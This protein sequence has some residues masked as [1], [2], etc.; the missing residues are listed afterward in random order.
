MSFWDDKQAVHRLH[1]EAFAPRPGLL[2][3]LD[4]ATGL[5]RI[6]KSQEEFLTWWSQYRQKGFH[7]DDMLE[8]LHHEGTHFLQILNCGYL[9]FLASRL[10]E[11]VLRSSQ[12]MIQTGA[13]EPVLSPILAPDLRFLLEH[14]DAPGPAR[15]TPRAIVE[16]ATFHTQKRYWRQDLDAASYAALLDRDCPGEDYRDAY[17]VAVEIIGESAYNSFQFISYR[18]LCSRDPAKSF[19]AICE[20]VAARR[21]RLDGYDRVSASCPDDIMP[22][23]AAAD[24]AVG[25]DHI[26]GPH[27]VMSGMQGKFVPHRVYIDAIADYYEEQSKDLTLDSY[28]IAPHLTSN[29]ILLM[30]R[31]PLLFNQTD[32]TSRAWNIGFLDRTGRRRSDADYKGF[33]AT[34]A[35]ATRLIGHVFAVAYEPPAH[36]VLPPADIATAVGWN[37]V[38]M[39]SID[40]DYDLQDRLARLHYCILPPESAGRN[41]TWAE[42][43]H[44]KPDHDLVDHL[45]DWLNSDSGG[46]AFSPSFPLSPKRMLMVT[47]IKPSVLCCFWLRGDFAGRDAGHADPGRA[48]QSDALVLIL[49]GH[50]EAQEQAA[51]SQWNPLPDSDKSVP[52]DRPLVLMVC[53]DSEVGSNYYVEQMNRHLATAFL[54]NLA[55]AKDS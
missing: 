19:V 10:F 15:L 11:I 25:T 44:V 24:K 51:L 31:Q 39:D 5:I 12:H 33:L 32:P 13:A 1:V 42:A 8:T 46:F 41:A 2:A 53:N 18:A 40:R 7:W 21:L 55:A 34:A 3:Y 17:D 27:L 30:L 6:N 45:A 20:E 52:S 48:K 28:V 23:V 29:D 37:A 26:G 50:D 38:A 54:R 43:T 16:S 9:Y 22:F 14:F 35:L 49:P 36:P 4:L 47:R